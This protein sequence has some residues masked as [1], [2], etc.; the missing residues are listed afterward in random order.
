MKETVINNEHRY[1][2]IALIS[3][4]SVKLTEQPIPIDAF[5]YL[6]SLDAEGLRDINEFVDLQLFIKALRA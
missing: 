3:E 6:C 4:K 5:D 2:L 1:A